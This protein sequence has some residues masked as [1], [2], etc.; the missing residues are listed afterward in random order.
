MGQCTHVSTVHDNHELTVLYM[1][2]A[3]STH[4]AATNIPPHVCKEIMDG[5]IVLVRPATLYSESS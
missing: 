2:V 3:T 1:L 4:P 5:N